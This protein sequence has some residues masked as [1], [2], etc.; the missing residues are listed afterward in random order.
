MPHSLKWTKRL[1]DAG[2]KHLLLETSLFIPVG[3][4]CYMQLSGRPI[5]D[6]YSHSQQAKPANKRKLSEICSKRRVKGLK[7]STQKPHA[8]EPEVSGRHRGTPRYRP[9]C[10][11][12]IELN[13][14]RPADINIPRQKMFYGQP[15]R[16]ADGKLFHGLPAQ[17]I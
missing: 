16:R 3:N 11:L 4:N 13:S 7:K 10:L 5:Y 12:G 6:L 15:A 1:G 17:R 2:F 8:G 14:H 9:H